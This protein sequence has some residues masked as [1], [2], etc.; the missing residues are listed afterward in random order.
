MILALSPHLDDAVLSAGGTLAARAAAGEEVVLATAFT[1]SVPDP[2]GFALACQQGIG[3]ETDPMALRREEDRAAAQRLGIARTV[4]L[5]LP[6]AQHRGYGSAAALLAAPRDDDLVHQHLAT[7]IARLVE[8]FAATEVYAPQ[9]LGGHVD[10]VQLVRALELAELSVGVA[11]WRDTPAV[12]SDDIPP[13][14]GERVEPIAATL[15]TKLAAA[16]AYASQLTSL[17]GGEEAMRA[18]ITA[19][20]EREGEGTPG[21]RFAH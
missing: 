21:E 10:H 8:R 18:T 17:F 7:A 19:L 12:V 1:L 2:E 13:T 15:A 11:R 5:P 3:P 16:A 9:G 6:E 20:A 4:H 14:P